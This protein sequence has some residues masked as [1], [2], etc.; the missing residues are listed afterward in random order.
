MNFYVK[1]YLP[2]YILLFILIIL[3]IVTFNGTMGEDEGRFS[4]M[5]RIWV[6]N[7]LPPYS[8]SV[9]NKTPGI[10]IINAISY[11]IF[12]TNIIFVRLLGIL[13]IG[14]SSSL[15]FKINKKLHSFESAIIS[16]LIFGLAMSW[17]AMDGAF[18]SY[19]E[20]FMILFIV[21][22]FYIVISISLTKKWF[23]WA[24][25]AGISMGF[26]ISLKQIAITSTFALILY[27]LLNNYKNKTFSELI[28]ILIFVFLGIILASIISIIPLVISNVTITEYINGAWLLLFDD[29]STPT[30]LNRFLSARA[31]WLESRI[32][33]FYPFLLFLILQTHL[34]KRKYI[35]GLIIWLL[36]DFIGVNASGY[37]FG[38][39]IKQIV[40]SLSILIGI[41]IAEQLRSVEKRENNELV[42]LKRFL[43]VLAFLMLPFNQLVDNYFRYRGNHRSD[44]N[45]EI[46]LYI[47]QNSLPN[48]YVYIMSNANALLSYTDRVSSTKYFNPLFVNTTIEHQEV[49]NNLLIKPP[50]FIIQRKFE[51]QFT[52]PERYHDYVKNNYIIHKEMY[53]FLIFKRIENITDL[54]F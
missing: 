29:G 34:L 2:Q 30:L 41:I 14:L 37:Y 51:K 17:R 6:E 53:E 12:G 28:Y 31:L 50:K 7:N 1:K 5:G 42:Y 20:S 19:T 48:D 47:K 26:A 38:H 27:I 9:E 16:M 4:Y 11:F 49:L 22:S 15:I 3:T 24:I 54:Q 13:S 21:I 45:K 25:S 40:P 44:P 8:E 36:F 23:Y 46:G 32:V 10:F 52:F 18:T 43:V 35:I 33:F 39:Q